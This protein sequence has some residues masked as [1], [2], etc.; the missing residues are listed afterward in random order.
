MWNQL[1]PYQRFIWMGGAL[2]GVALL[3]L[4]FTLPRA[5]SPS[6]PSLSNRTALPAQKIQAVDLL[7]STT[8]TNDFAKNQLIWSQAAMPSTPE[9]VFFRHPFT[10]TAT[11]TKP[12]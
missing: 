6:A 2:F 7:T 12:E 9:V 1:R 4:F 8:T 5:Q 11:L 3:L 10:L